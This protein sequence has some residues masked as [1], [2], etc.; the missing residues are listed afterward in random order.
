V[1]ALNDSG[2]VGSDALVAAAWVLPPEEERDL[3]Q[4]IALRDAIADGHVRAVVPSLWIHEVGNTL[5]RRQPERA[6]RS[7]D[8][9]LRFNLASAPRSPRW[10]ECALHLT[11]RYGVTFH[12]A[13]YHAHAIVGRGVFV[14]ADERYIGRTGGPDP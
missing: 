6:K 11:Q 2:T 13:S 4:A 8:A 3:A 10:L 9:L 7:L 12:D 5:A 1:E 14:T